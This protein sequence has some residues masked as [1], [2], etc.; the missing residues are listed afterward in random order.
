[1]QLNDAQLGF[2]LGFWCGCERMRIELQRSRRDDRA[3]QNRD[4]ARTRRND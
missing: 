1:M 3:H 2:L 4:A